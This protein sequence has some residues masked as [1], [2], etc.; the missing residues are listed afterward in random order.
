MGLVIDWSGKNNMLLKR[1]IYFRLF[2]IS[3]IGALALSL[4]SLFFLVMISDMVVEDYRYGY[5]MYLGRKIEK[6]SE[7][8]PVS[9]INVN[10]YPAPPLPSKNALTILK[11]TEIAGPVPTPERVTKKGFLEKMPI[12]KGP[13]PLLW[14]V[15]EQGTIISAN[16]NDPLPSS[17]LNLPHPRRIH[18]MKN[19]DNFLLKPKTFVIRLNTIPTTFLV[20]HNPRSLFQGPFLWIQGLHTFTTAALAV[21]LA[22]SI[23]VYYLR[24]KSSEAREVLEKLGSGDLKSRLEI[25]RFDQFGNLILD[26]N[27][28]ADEIERLVKRL[29]DTETSRSNLLQELGHDLRTPLT[30]LGTSFEALKYYNEQM[31]SEDRDEVFS[32]IDAD[33]RYFKDL[34]EK[35]TIVATIDESHYKVS[36]EKIDLAKMLENE[37]RNRQTGSGQEIIWMF[38]ASGDKTYDLFGDFHLIS[39]LFK[40]AFDNAARYAQSKIQVEILSKDDTLEVV[41]KDDG[42][43]LT[44]EA[45]KSFGKRRER[46]EVMERVPRNFSLGLGSVIMRTIAEV[47]GGKIIIA[48]AVNGGAALRIIFKLV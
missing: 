33:I 14:L 19:T 25:K 11:V 46:R 37:L 6:S 24:R 29:N 20:T 23:S 26:F 18:G 8:Y 5:M 35:L 30:S 3:M 41:V 48:N 47:H 4:I 10:K 2:L 22:L 34:L 42:P 45:I 44:A 21:F 1:A 38:K 43:G 9:K 17:W 16:T 36:S 15:S 12:E 13:R 7:D 27:R 28:M 39:R 31:S 32:M 40:N